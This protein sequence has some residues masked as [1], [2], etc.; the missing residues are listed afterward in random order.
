MIHFA[1]IAKMQN[2]NA[3]LRNQIE[4]AKLQQN[5]YHQEQLMAFNQH[6]IKIESQI[7]SDKLEF[8]K[9]KFEQEKLAQKEQ[10]QA[11]TKIAEIQAKSQE[12]QTMMTNGNN[13][14]VATI[15]IIGNLLQQ[16]GQL[17][18]T[19]ILKAL[20]EKLAQRQHERQ[21]E[22]LKLEASLKVEWANAEAHVKEKLM[23]L[24]QK[25]SM[26]RSVFEHNARL[27][28]SVVDSKLKDGSLSIL[29]QDDFSYEKGKFSQFVA[30]MVEQILGAKVQ[31]YFDESEIKNE[32]GKAADKLARSAYSPY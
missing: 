10:I 26:K 32:I 25:L 30:S 16:R 4:Q 22:L 31:K 2:A 20:E 5:H 24:E 13:I 7:Q 18:H 29:L 19:V 21:K 11:Q 17:Y 27:L 28:E 15:N 1:S 12:E 23:K 14:D 8:E 6:K 3:Y 9:Y